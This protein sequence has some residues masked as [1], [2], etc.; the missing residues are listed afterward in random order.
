[1][2][3]TNIG[4]VE[5]NKTQYYR[6]HKG[7]FSHVPH[8]MKLIRNHFIYNGFVYGNLSI[9][10]PCYEKIPSHHVGD[11]KLILK[12]TNYKK[13][14]AC[15]ERNFVHWKNSSELIITINDWFDASNVKT[16]SMT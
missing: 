16:K 12:I 13:T 3:V 9:S 1:M 2:A 5:E 6:F 10:K 15:R 8:D 14:V 4:L 7:F 11:F